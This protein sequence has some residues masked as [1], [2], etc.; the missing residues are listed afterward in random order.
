M[1]PDVLK[2]AKALPAKHVEAFAKK[3][4]MMG[5]IKER[6]GGYFPMLKDQIER[7]GFKPD[8]KLANA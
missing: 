5:E 8:K 4:I 7:A 3:F 6:L 2:D 1:N